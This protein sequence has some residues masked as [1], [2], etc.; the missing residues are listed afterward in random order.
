MDIRSGLDGLK[1]LLGV[2]QPVP[3][4]AATEPKANTVAE[5]NSALDADRATL[6]TAGSEVAQTAGDGIVREDKVASIRAQLAAG[7]YD[8]SASAVATRM[9]DALLAAG[10]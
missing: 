8:V 4:A 2:P 7:T 9:V 1:S 3:A 10:N 5:S 6:S